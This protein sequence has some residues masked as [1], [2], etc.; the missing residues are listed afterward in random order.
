MA[1][2]L[3]FESIDYDEFD[4]TSYRAIELWHDHELV[5]RFA[6]G[7]LIADWQA[8]EQWLYDHCDESDMIGSS[9]S[10]DHFFSDGN[11]Y[12]IDSNNNVGV[13]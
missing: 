13:S 8:K 1:N 3:Y 11:I 7:N 5:A 2:Q 12:V 4:Q 9:S 10:V 6:T